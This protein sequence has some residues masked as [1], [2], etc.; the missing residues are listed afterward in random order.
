MPS[1]GYN[2]ESLG[3]L[4][5]QLNVSLDVLIGLNTNPQ[6]VPVDVVYNLETICYGILVS[7]WAL[8][9]FDMPSDALSTDKITRIDEVVE[10]NIVS[11]MGLQDYRQLYF[12]VSV[13]F[14]RIP[15]ARRNETT[16]AFVFLLC[17]LTRTR[18]CVK[19]AH[20]GKVLIHESNTLYYNS[21]IFSHLHTFIE[22]K[23]VP[24]EGRGWNDTEKDHFFT[25][26]LS[27]I[28]SELDYADMNEEIMR[29][30]FENYEMFRNALIS[31]S[32]TE[33]VCMRDSLD[34][35]HDVFHF[36]GFSYIEHVPFNGSC[37]EK[38]DNRINEYLRLCDDFSDS[39]VKGG[40]VYALSSF[41]RPDKPERILLTAVVSFSVQRL[42]SGGRRHV[43]I[44]TTRNLKHN[45]EF[46]C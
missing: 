20:R 13:G 1:D 19:L 6:F 33:G 31:N 3:I 16:E 45:F 25:R 8:F 37:K 32:Y 26:Y 12:A 22:R 40:I 30:T 28:K 27:L 7:I 38:I 24:G 4:L 29:M 44:M 9:N 41:R 15:I 5:S 11:L 23:I 43:R 21:H 18:I 14:L 10:S 46:F 2:L 35:V 17:M 42:L 34:M 36:I 39:D